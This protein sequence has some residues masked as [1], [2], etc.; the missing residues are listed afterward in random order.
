MRIEIVIAGMLGLVLVTLGCGK[1]MSQNDM[2]KYAIQRPSDNENAEPGGAKD[3][4][5]NASAPAASANRQA[6]V[7]A[8]D[9]VTGQSAVAARNSAPKTV[10]EHLRAG[11]GTGHTSPA[12]SNEDTAGTEAAAAEAAV[13][14]TTAPVDANPP[15]EGPR[16]PSEPLDEAERRQRTINNM[17]QI[18]HAMDAYVKANGRFPTPAICASDD[19][20]LLSW[21][22]ALLPYLGHEPLYQQFDQNEPWDGPHNQQLLARIPEVYQSPERFDVKTNYLVPRGSPTVFR[23]NRPVTTRRIDDGVSNTVILLEVDDELAVPWTS[24]QDYPVQIQTPT[25]GLGSLRQD[26]FF[27]VFGGGRVRHVSAETNRQKVWAMYTT[28]GGESLTYAQASS[29]ALAHVSSAVPQGDPKTAPGKGSP[30]GSPAGT[31]PVTSS[32]RGAPTGANSAARS[33]GVPQHA[34]TE[35]PRLA[36]PSQADQQTSRELFREVYQQRYDDARTNSAKRDLANEMLQQA[37]QIDP[38]SADRYVLLQVVQRIAVEIA[39]TDLTEQAVLELEQSYDVDKLA[40]REAVV[41]QLAK[42]ARTPQ[43]HEYVYRQARRLVEH[44]LADDLFGKARELHRIALAEGRQT[45]NVSAVRALSKLKR[46][47]LTSEAR[48]E[49]V[50]AALEGADNPLLRGQVNRVVG[51][52]YCFCKGQWERGLPLLAEADE[53]R[54]QRLAQ[55]DLQR[56]ATPE[57]QVELADGWWTVAEEDESGAQRHPRQRAV[58]WYRIALPQLPAGLLK[59]KVEMRLKEAERI[60][61]RSDREGPDMSFSGNASKSWFVLTRM[62]R[63]GLPFFAPA[64]MTTC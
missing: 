7:K 50:Q 56:P 6:P 1:G 8:K 17:S 23:G 5:A 20:E 46:V 61:G 3:A 44:A 36:V 40:L 55:T 4:S 24:P 43:D 16:P 58:Y 37:K 52:Y 47:I 13:T 34:G 45:N 10:P 38:A 35:A 12:A 62:P 59:T 2:M 54:L 53:P 15:A 28:D 27:V 39:D 42:K 22:V 33:R 41:R 31:T 48:Y 14:G 32:T 9:H 21:R 26:G 49:Q 30:P 60:Q 25:A 19:T 51:Q 57:A 18:G 11:G 64:S 29:P 63:S